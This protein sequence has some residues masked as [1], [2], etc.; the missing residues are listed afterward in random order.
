V[1]ADS[2]ALREATGRG[3]RTGRRHEAMKALPE[4]LY[5]MTKGIALSPGE[6]TRPRVLPPAPR[7]WHF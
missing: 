2:R 7:R 5:M 4:V 3:A 1:P 6:H